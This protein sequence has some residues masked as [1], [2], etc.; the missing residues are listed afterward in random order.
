MRR[1]LAL[2][3]FLP[4]FAFAAPALKVVVYDAQ[5]V[6]DVT[7]KRLLKLADAALKDISALEVGEGSLTRRDALKRCADAVA[8][9]RDAA[10][11]AG[12]PA[13]MLVSARTSH[14]GLV[15]EAS[16]FLDGEKLTGPELG[17][18]EIDA[19]ADSLKT[20]FESA[21][22]KWARKGYGGVQVFAPAG[23]VVKIDGK[24]FESSRNEILPVAVGTHQVDVLFASGEAELSQVEV[25]AGARV[26]LEPQPP[27]ASLTR[28]VAPSESLSALRLT[29][30]GAW[31]G[32]ALLTASGFIAGALSRGTA[33]GSKPCAMT[34]RDC[35]TFTQAEERSRLAQSYAQTGNVLLGIGLALAVVG[36]GLFVLDLSFSSSN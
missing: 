19:G 34:T 24:V 15:V 32:G 35:I 20:L 26:R 2:I 17:E 14:K 30:Y 29:S 10:A 33:S 6:P 4:A 36:A 1:P 12:V 21:L 7:A 23:A 18:T 27:A 28:A 9:E 8:C 16:F 5:G 31:M 11:K 25:A 3:A 22:P 13:A